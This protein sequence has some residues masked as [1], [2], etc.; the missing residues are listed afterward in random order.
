MA[1]DQQ[2]L[3]VVPDDLCGIADRRLGCGITAPMTPIVPTPLLSSRWA[4]PTGWWR[5]WIKAEVMGTI[6][7]MRVS[8]CPSCAKETGRG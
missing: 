4:P 7:D 3:E 5:G 1:K 8:L 6:A 2:T